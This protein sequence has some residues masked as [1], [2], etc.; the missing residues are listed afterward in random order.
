VGKDKKFWEVKAAANDVGEL[1]IYGD[2]TSYK[3]DDTDITA[4]S[5]A[6]DLKALG[7]IKTLNVYVNSLGGSVFQGQ[8]IYS[9]LKRH[10][11]YKNVYIDGIAASIASVIAM[12]GDTVLMPK[13]AM[14]MIHNPWTF[15]MGNSA[16]LRKEADALDKIRESMIVAYMDKI[17]DKT[18]EE[19]LVELLDAETWLSAQEAFDY[20]FCDELLDEKEIAAS[21]LDSKMLSNYKNTPDSIKNL[22]KGVDRLSDD[23]KRQRIIEESRADLADLNHILRN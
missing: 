13:N 4:K 14:V 16:D 21:C 5:F 12:A 17:Q 22:Q 10:S 1:Y 20:G 11:A 2:I 15:A 7:D 8:A 23:G 3:W 18:T 6:E 9:V 19:K